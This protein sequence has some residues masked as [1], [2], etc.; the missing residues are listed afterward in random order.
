MLATS[1]PLAACS[2]DAPDTQTR[3]SSPSTSQA[4]ARVGDAS[5]SLAQYQRRLRTAE[6]TYAQSRGVSGS[7]YYVPPNF[8]ICVVNRRRLGSDRPQAT[9]SMVRAQCRR[10]YEYRR[11]STLSTMIEDLW[12]KQ[13]A[14]TQGLA[15]PSDPYVRALAFPARLARRTVEAIDRQEI[16]ESAIARYYRTHRRYFITPEQRVAR[17]IVSST[18][19]RARQAKRALD[20]GMGWNAAARSYGQPGIGSEP[21]RLAG[22]RKLFDFGLRAPFFGARRGVVIAPVHAQAGWYALQV[23]AIEPPRLLSL[24]ESRGAI[25]T[26]LAERRHNQAAIDYWS[27]VRRTVRARTVCLVRLTVPECRN[28]SRDDF[29]PDGTIFTQRVKKPSL[30]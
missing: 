8:R 17:A 1:L 7:R 12:I 18:P 3:G 29:D 4:I 23:R 15:P 25:A 27:R 16:S 24:A 11:S 5:I 13:E 21:Q 14:S 9:D 6:R 19:E 26:F 10:N 2:D 22:S 20:E 30:P 28:G